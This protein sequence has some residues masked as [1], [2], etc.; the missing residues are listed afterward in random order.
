MEADQAQIQQVVMNLITNASEAIGENPGAIVVSSGVLDC[1]GSYLAQSRIDEK[2][3]PGRYL[4]LDVTD[5]GTGMTED[6][7]ARMFDPFFSTKSTGRGLGMSAVLGIVR[8]HGGAIMI[9]SVVGE[10]TTVRVLLPASGSLPDDDETGPS[11]SFR[12]S[13]GSGTLLVVDDEEEVRELAMEFAAEIGLH[14]LCA[15][16]G[17]EALGLFREHKEE[18]ACV[19]LDLTMPKMDGVETFARL[20]QIRSDVRVLLSSGYDEQE[21]IQ[22]H[23]LTGLAGFIQKPYRL[24][25][26]R[27]KVMEI[28]RLR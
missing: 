24:D 2:A 26:L 20:R 15:A 7:I 3:L 12:R 19:L 4:N 16:N 22:R 27:E 5:T 10:G 6:V 23:A 14:A 1:D 18:I 21:V 25:Q 11:E 17:E 8:G 13:A 28:V 9:D